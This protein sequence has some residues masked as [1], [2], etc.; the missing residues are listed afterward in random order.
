M[1][2]QESTSRIPE[3]SLKPVRDKPI[4]TQLTEVIR[5]GVQKVFLDGTFYP[6]ETHQFSLLTLYSDIEITGSQGT[7]LDGKDNITHLIYVADGI[8]VKIKGVTFTGGNTQNRDSQQSL[9]HHP[10][11]RLNIFRYLDGGAISMGAGSRVILEDC[12]FENN[13]SAICGGAISNLGGYLHVLNCGFLYNSCGDT[14]AAI[15]NLGKGSLTVIEQSRF[16][17]NTANGL[18]TGTF[19]AVTAFPDTYLI[20]KNSDFSKQST[21]AIDYTVNRRKKQYIFIDNQTSFNPKAPN[22]IEQNPKSN[23]GTRTEIIT[24]YSQIFAAHPRLVKFEVIPHA[25]HKTIEKHKNL[26]TELTSVF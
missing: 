6:E 2:I 20:V 26:F 19:G 3:I 4:Q 7:T 22:A 15:D 9:S 16:I 8:T 21:T 10:G 17:E 25:D 1:P 5:N 18:G 14:G 23:S 13:H 11:N 24:R 12:I